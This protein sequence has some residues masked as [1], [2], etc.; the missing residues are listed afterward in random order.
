M[1]TQVAIA[2]FQK[3]KASIKKVENI[4]IQLTTKNERKQRSDGNAI[5]VAM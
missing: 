1:A 3:R 4:H 5:I 2:N